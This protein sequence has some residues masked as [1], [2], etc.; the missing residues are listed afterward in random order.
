MKNSDDTNSLRCHFSLLH[1]SHA[2]AKTESEN[3]RRAAQGTVTELHPAV[4]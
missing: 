1:L 2:S 3:N 4:H